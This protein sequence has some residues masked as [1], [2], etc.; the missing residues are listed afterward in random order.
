MFYPVFDDNGNVR[1]LSII[2]PTERFKSKK[3]CD[4]IVKAVSEVLGEE[5]GDWSEA[6]PE[7]FKRELARLKRRAKTSL[8]PRE[9]VRISARNGKLLSVVF[10]HRESKEIDRRIVWQVVNR[11]GMYI[12]AGPV[13]EDIPLK[14]AELLLTGRT[15]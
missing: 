11:I 13:A 7:V 14:S 12:T 3:L 4:Q 9:A 5:M 10:V 2:K 8:T 1:A 15:G 6:E